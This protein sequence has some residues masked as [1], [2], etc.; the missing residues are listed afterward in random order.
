MQILHYIFIVALLF[1]FV[2]L[3][4]I[5]VITGQKS[6]CG[7]DDDINAPAFTPEPLV[8]RFRPYIIRP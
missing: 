7:L 6:G 5:K 3:I 8:L 1:A 2:A 4:C